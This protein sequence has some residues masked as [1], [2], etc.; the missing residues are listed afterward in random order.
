MPVEYVLKRGLPPN[1]AEKFERGQ[2]SHVILISHRRGSGGDPLE[3]VVICMSRRHEYIDP[4]GGDENPGG[5]DPNDWRS[6]EG[7]DVDEG[8]KSESPEG[9]CTDLEAFKD[10]DASIQTS[11]RRCKTT[12]DLCYL[13][14]TQTRRTCVRLGGSAQGLALCSA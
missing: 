12:G 9:G 7:D 2:Y 3:Q 11:Y 8:L 5:E 13:L 1:L 14:I 6:L 4:N 10:V